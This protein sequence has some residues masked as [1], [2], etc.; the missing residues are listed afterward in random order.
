MAKKIPFEKDALKKFIDSEIKFWR[1]Q[2]LLHIS[3]R[4]EF[5]T[6]RKLEGL[7]E[8]YQHMRLAVFGAKLK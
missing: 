5:T 7:I 4:K 8:A 6:L 2:R 1:Q 3:K